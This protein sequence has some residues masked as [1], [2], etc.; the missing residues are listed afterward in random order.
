MND[1]SRILRAA[2]QVPW[3]M[4]PAKLAEI[5]AFLQARANGNE[6]SA[7]EKEALLKQAEDR[8]RF[9]MAGSV[10]V[11]PVMGTVSQRL[12]MLSATSGGTST[13]LLEKQIRDAVADTSVSAI[14]LNVDSPGGTVSG[15]PELHAAILNAR[16]Q[17]PIA[18]SI[19]SMS[20]SAAYWITSAVKDISI[21]P[22]GEAGSIGVF[23]MHE[24]YSA[25]LAEDGVKVTL[26]SAA[27]YKTEGNPYE[28]LTAEA[29]A[30]IQSDVDAY[31]AMFV[32]DVAKG[33]GVSQ[34][35]VK[36]D[37]GEGRMLLAADAVKAGMVDRIETLQD[38]ITRL[39]GSRS[40]GKRSAA[41]GAVSEMGAKFR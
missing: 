30:A 22:S 4:L 35:S 11:I 10:A 16:D 24:D 33:R 9:T 2:H 38:T 27:K 6:I 40:T 3:A 32:R 15:L 17:K 21:S 8:Q 29:R 39:S 26:I 19:N 1:I 23:A 28:P 5:R 37:F 18:A 20:A 25:M 31:Y 13:E 41:L 34:S 36:V 14:V 7:A 12:N